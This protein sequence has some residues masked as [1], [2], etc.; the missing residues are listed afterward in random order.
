[1]TSTRSNSEKRISSQNFKLKIGTTMKMNP[2]VIYIEGRT[3][4]SPL[5]YKDDYSQDISEIKRTFRLA[6]GD[7]IRCS[8]LFENN[9]IVDFQVASK[10]IMP[11]KKSFLSF[12]FFLKQNRNNI[13]KLKDL[14]P[15][16]ENIVNNIVQSLETDIIGHN[17]AISKTKK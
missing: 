13:L 12:Q 3:F 15:S 17:F 2:L 1:M 10:G 5:S 8:D 9:Y 6:I 7:N 16:A 14:K 4:I 11:N